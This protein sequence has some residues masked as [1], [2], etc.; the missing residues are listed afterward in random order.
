MR[1]ESILEYHSLGDPKTRYLLL[2]D[3][4]MNC[5]KSMKEAHKSIIREPNSIDNTHIN[6]TS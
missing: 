3:V 2:Y 1:K 4:S 6:T 5:I